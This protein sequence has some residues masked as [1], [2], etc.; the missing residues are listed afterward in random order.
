VETL[1]L[2]LT[3]V[4]LLHHKEGIGTF[5]AIQTKRSEI[6]G[7][8][9]IVVEEAMQFGGSLFTHGF[10]HCSLPSHYLTVASNSGNMGCYRSSAF[11]STRHLKK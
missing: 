10:E 1:V 3:A 8:S 9:G 6:R 2:S 11:L 7:T 5:F 4:N